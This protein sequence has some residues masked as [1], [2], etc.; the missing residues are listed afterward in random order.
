MKFVQ[1]VEMKTKKMDELQK[2]A[3][4]YDA[5]VQ[6]RNTDTHVLICQDR[7]VADRYF[8]IVE[9]PSP[10]AAKQNDELPETQEFAQKQAALLD[11]PPNFYN[12]D[13]ID[14]QGG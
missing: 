6:G 1:I 9:F 14:E 10:E 8:V 12:L 4:D 13:V 5:K 7:D 11:G 3:E 2:L